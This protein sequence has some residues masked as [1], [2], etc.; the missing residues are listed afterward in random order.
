[1]G[2]LNSKIEFA[3]GFLVI[4]T[5]NE[6]LYCCNLCLFES[7]LIL[8]LQAHILAE[9]T[10]NAEQI[11]SEL[12]VNV[13]ISQS[14]R[15]AEFV[16]T[17]SLSKNQLDNENSIKMNISAA[18]DVVNQRKI[19]EKINTV[20]NLD[21]PNS[22]AE[23]K[24]K[25]TVPSNPND[26]EIFECG[27]CLPGLSIF[28]K[29]RRLKE[30]LKRHAKQKLQKPCEI[31]N[32]RVKNYDKHMKMNHIERRPYVCEICGATFIQNGHKK[33]HMRSHTGE[34]PFICATC[35]MAFKCQSTL[36]K[37]EI[38][39]LQRKPYP[40]SQCDRSFPTPYTLKEH[41]NS[42]HSNE[43]N[44]ECNI[45]GGR[46]KTRKYLRQHKF[47]HGEKIHQVCKTAVKQTVE[48]EFLQNFCSI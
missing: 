40:C 22:K 23:T 6:F 36:A 38:R 31:C 42:F 10:K 33:I 44:Y 9:H 27:I 16:E 15:R 13:W 7:S 8:H 37:H 45:C 30:H 19:I 26:S 35:G 11:S 32:K 18:S 12:S 14:P 4:N 48:F 5:S 20:P 47:S 1:M 43:R 17:T 21:E 2:F 25:S 39:H 29:K 46:F 34:R 24:P 41:T 28:L 3:C